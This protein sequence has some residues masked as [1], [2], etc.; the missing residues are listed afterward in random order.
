MKK[1]ILFLI[2]GFL[3]GMY[4]IMW[5]TKD[6]HIEKTIIDGKVYEVIKREIDTVVVTHIQTVVKQGKDVFHDRPVYVPVTGVVDTA[7]ILRHYNSLQA[8]T[9]TLTL[10]RGVGMVVIKD[11]LYR[12]Q[13]RSR[14]YEA[15]LNQTTISEKVFLKEPSKSHLW[16]GSQVANVGP[17]AVI[18]YQTK[19]GTSMYEVGVNVLNPGGFLGVR[20]KIK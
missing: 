3:F 13:L 9:D 20:F 5:F 2:V 19:K 8:I 7:A 10:D 1:T 12:N 4:L 18:G 14:I 11:T 6:R 16:V 15:T 17:S